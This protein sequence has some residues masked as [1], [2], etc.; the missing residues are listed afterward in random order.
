[1][2][3][4]ETVNDLY[5]LRPG[6]LIMACNLSHYSFKNNDDDYS[7][8]NGYFVKQLLVYV[9]CDANNIGYHVLFDGETIVYVWKWFYRI[10]NAAI[11]RVVES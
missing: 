4:L 11:L 8:R 1:M 6:D 7:S 3:R 10:P 5:E 9:G 2:V